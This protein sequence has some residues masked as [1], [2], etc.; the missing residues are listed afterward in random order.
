MNNVHE[1]FWRKVR[2]GPSCWEWMG[3]KSRGYGKFKESGKTLLAHR[4]AFLLEF[5]AIPDGMNVCHH[6]D[7]R[8]C[9]RPE[10][11]FLGT[12]SDNVLDSVRKG[13][14]ANREGERNPS[15]KLTENDV[16]AI[17][18]M[19]N[20]E[21]RSL[22]SIAALFD[23]NFRNVSRIALGTTWKYLGRLNRAQRNCAEGGANK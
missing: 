8:S 14:W 21:G 22:S 20:D 18:R 16:I 4:V 9:V 6:C 12:D 5:G 10:H 23:T 2:L 7:N 3:T 19:R 11:L 15:A 1:R 17:R 13:R